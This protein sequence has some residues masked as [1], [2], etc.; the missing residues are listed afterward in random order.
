MQQTLEQQPLSDEP[1]QRWE[2]RDGERT[3]QE[4]RSR[5]RQASHKATKPVEVAATGRHLYRAGREEEAAFERS[6]VHHHEQCR[7]HRQPT[8]QTVAGRGEAPRCSD[9]D[10]YEPHVVRSGVGK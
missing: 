6:V 2:G 7:Y 9:T 5:D 3:N 8:D 4:H 1:V 10:E